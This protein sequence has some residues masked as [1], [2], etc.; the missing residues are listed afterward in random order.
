[1]RWVLKNQL[2]PWE[3]GGWFLPPLQNRNFV[4]IL[5]LV[6]DFYKLPIMGI[7]P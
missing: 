7:H 2:H 1:M 3:I 5:E 4:A 6:Q